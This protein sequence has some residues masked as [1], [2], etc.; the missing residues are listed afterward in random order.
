MFVKLENFGRFGVVSDTMN[1][2]LPVGTW[3]DARNIR[4]SGVMM[5]KMLEPTTFANLVDELGDP[6]PDGLWMQGWSDGNSTYVV[7]ATQTQLW[8]LVRG[9]PDDPGHFVDVSRAEGY[10]AEG[11][12]DSFSWGDTVIFNNTIDPPQIFNGATFEDLPNWGLLSTG[13]DISNNNPPSREVRVSCTILRPYKSF[14]VACGITE[15]GEYQ[16]NAV[17]WSDATALATFSTSVTNGGPPDWDYESPASLSGKSEVGI[18]NGAITAAELLNENVVIYTE[19][20]ATAMMNTGGGL[21][22][23]F[24]RLFEKGAAGIHCVAEFNNQHFVVSRDQLYLHNGS[25]P[26]LIAKDRIEEEFYTRIG[27][28][29]RFGG[30]AVPWDLVQV[31]KNPDRKEIYVIYGGDGF[32]DDYP[33]GGDPSPDPGPTDDICPDFPNVGLTVSSTL[34]DSAAV[35]GNGT[36]GPM[37]TLG[38][39]G[40]VIV[41]T[42]GE[43]SASI[44]TDKGATWTPFTLPELATRDTTKWQYNNGILYLTREVGSEHLAWWSDDNGATW[45]EMGLRGTGVNEWDNGSSMLSVDPTTGYIYGGGQRTGVGGRQW[46]WTDPTP[47]SGA[48][49]DW[50]NVNSTAGVFF[51]AVEVCGAHIVYRRQVSSYGVENFSGSVVGIMTKAITESG[52]ELQTETITGAVA[53]GSLGG[54]D[55]DHRQNTAAYQDQYVLFQPDTD[56]G[57]DIDYSDYQRATWHVVEPAVLIN[58][59]ENDPIPTMDVDFGRPVDMPRAAVSPNYY[60]FIARSRRPDISGDDKKI[61]LRWGTS[62]ASPDLSEVITVNLTFTPDMSDA[63]ARNRMHILWSQ[64]NEWVI[65]YQA[66]EDSQMKVELIDL[67]AET[68]P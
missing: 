32:G 47:G 25:K 14:L 22:M 15:G 60:V 6:I 27:K 4:F 7:V 21:V 65:A 48:L 55:A 17:W 50:E 24:R 45:T 44:S 28:G 40:D 18:G 46:V 59:A 36:L 61:F 52:W 41:Y 58:N 29:G 57:K 16:P 63:I 51:D 8:Y 26:V 13:A 30:E 35:T 5:E 19:R 56:D 23:S 11:K 64:G 31:V 66:Q 42:N 54:T 9:A 34:L 62:L 1:S 2:A 43:D 3:T 68:A 12:W 37:G 39:V 67:C 33:P 53:G 10:S 38:V 49:V 20:S